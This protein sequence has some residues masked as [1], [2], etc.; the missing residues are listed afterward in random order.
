MMDG[1]KNMNTKYPFGE[2][3]QRP[4]EKILI[5]FREDLSGFAERFETKRS[6]FCVG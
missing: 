2:K 4:L 1:P 5:S 3:R 6:F